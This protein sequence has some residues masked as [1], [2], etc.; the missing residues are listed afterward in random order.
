MLLLAS[1]QAKVVPASVKSEILVH[2]HRESTGNNS[3]S[4]NSIELCNFTDDEDV[5]KRMKHRSLARAKSNINDPSKLKSLKG[6]HERQ[7]RS[8]EHTGSSDIK[9]YAGHDKAKTRRNISFDNSF[10]EIVVKN[11]ESVSLERISQATLATSNVKT[12]VQKDS[13]DKVYLHV[14]GETMKNV[15]HLFFSSSFFERSRQ[16]FFFVL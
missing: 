16:V 14:N 3:K 6:L 8:I 5:L 15:F 12:S 10:P 9:T 2:P 1:A 7:V 11:G 4:P 13:S